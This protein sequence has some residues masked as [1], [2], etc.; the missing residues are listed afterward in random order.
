MNIG[1]NIKLLRQQNNITQETL[2]NHLGVSTQ[3]VSKWEVGA[4]TPDI[5]LLPPIAKYFNI[6]IDSLFSENIPNQSAL[7]DIPDDGIFRIIQFRGKEIVR[8]TET[9][10]QNEPPMEIILPRNCND[11][12]GYFKIEV[13]GHMICDS[14]ING[15]VVCH[16]TLSCNEINGDV[17]TEGDIHVFR[18]NAQKVNCKNVINEK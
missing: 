18:I 16:K 17:R 10:S 4:N 15:D 12:T 6:T 2:A 7:C 1:R 3:A 13:F 9:F 5:S 14:S 8:V 11:K